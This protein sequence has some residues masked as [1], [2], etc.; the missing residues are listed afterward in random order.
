VDGVVSKSNLVPLPCRI[1]HVVCILAF[2][3]SNLHVRQ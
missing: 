3:L 1:N 2:K